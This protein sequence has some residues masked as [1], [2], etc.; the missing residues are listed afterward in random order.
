MSLL[1]NPFRNRVLQGDCIELMRQMETAS[2]DFILTDPPTSAAIGHVTAKPSP[3]T[4]TTHGSN[5]RSPKCT[6]S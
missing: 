4:T 3:M 5:P 6:A 1:A 2:V